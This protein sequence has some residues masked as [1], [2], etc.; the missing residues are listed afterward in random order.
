MG[1]TPDDVDDMH[2][3]LE[4][5]FSATATHQATP[6]PTID[7]GDDNVVVEGEVT[8]YGGGA[9]TASMT[10]S[11]SRKW[12]CTSDVWEDINKIFAT[13]NGVEVTIGARC[14][15]CKKEFSAR[16]TIGTD[17]LARHRENA[18]GYMVELGT[19]PCLD[20]M[21]MLVFFVGNI[22]LKLLVCSYAV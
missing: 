10:S 21:L 4:E 17:H 15:F 11:T 16:S 5:L 13:E 1:Q 6:T 2:N 8:P 22:V 9:V 18:N 20:A 12:K 7:L 3:G 19:N 14:H